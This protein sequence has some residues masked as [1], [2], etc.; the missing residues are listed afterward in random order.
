MSYNLRI[1]TSGNEV[2]LYI[3][4]DYCIRTRGKENEFY[5]II[6]PP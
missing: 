6:K 4:K 3:S 1:I 2:E 5:Q